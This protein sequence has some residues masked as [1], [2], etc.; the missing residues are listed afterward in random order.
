MRVGI[1]VTELRPGAVGG[2]ATGLRLLLDA[3]RRHAPEVELVAYA[4]RPV[5]VPAGV[6]MVA[7][8]GPETPRRWRRSGALRRHARGLDLFHSPVTAFPELEGP[9]VTATVHE[10]PF[11]ENVRLEGEAR[12]LVQWYWL[13]RAMSRC[14]ALVA[15]SRAT[16]RQIGLAHPAARRLTHVVPHPAPPTPAHE[17]KAHEGYLLFVG[18]LDRRKR[19][20]ALL[21]GA[22]ALSASVRLVG[23]Q[24]E[25]GR[26]RIERVAERLGL[27][28]RVRFLGRVDDATLDEL[29]RKAL[30]VALLSASEG[31]GFPVLEAL[32]RGVPVVVAEGTG[33]AE[34]GGDAALAACL[35]SRRA[36]AA[37]L[38]RAA[39][40]AW[41]AHVAVRG[42]A[43]ALEFTA[44]RTAR[45][46]VEVFRR[47]LAR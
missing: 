18:R 9:A 33:A 22:A 30:L 39:E 13:S 2:V 36:V 12:A 46:Y 10:L 29:Y 3:L 38:T 17:Q 26:I 7:T 8:G 44:E 23:P 19:V 47:A 32:Q 4:P 6:A 40:P 43:R 15:P 24:T 5:D 37:A 45:G 16:L 34:V 27:R 11:V 20:E 14:R 42:P 35:T 21:Q 1:D 31:F 28:E 41:R 25:L